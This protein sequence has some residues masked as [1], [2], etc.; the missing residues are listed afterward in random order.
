MCVTHELAIIFAIGDNSV[1][2]D[3]ETKTMIDRTATSAAIGDFRRRLA[4]ARNGA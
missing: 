2:L 3:R 4:T 1:F